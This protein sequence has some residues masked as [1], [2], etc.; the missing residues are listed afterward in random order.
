M[1]DKTGRIIYNKYNKRKQEDTK[2]LSAIADVV[3]VA[4]AWW[5]MSRVDIF[6]D[7][8]EVGTK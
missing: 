2:V 1:L 8:L 6:F 7:R 3:F 5:A 4:V